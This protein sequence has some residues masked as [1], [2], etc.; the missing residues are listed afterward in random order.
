[1]TF[2]AVWCCGCNQEVQARL[3]NGQE[4]YP[5]RNDLKRIPFWVCDTCRNY[6]GCHWKRPEDEKKPLGSIPTP[7]L[8]RARTFVHNTVDP[9]WRSGKVDR[10]QLYERLASI[11][12][13]PFHVAELR[14]FA[15]VNKVLAT[16][17]E[18][19]DH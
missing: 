1:V 6:V 13:V 10:T 16:L 8:R 12:G 5:H 4:I 19:K 17:R 7:A 3:T 18:M 2:V 14:T 9:L 11:L 15:D